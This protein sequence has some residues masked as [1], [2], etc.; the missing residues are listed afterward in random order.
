LFGPAAGIGIFDAFAMVVPGVPLI[1]SEAADEE[2]WR[3][4]APGGAVKVWSGP[5]NGPRP[6]DPIAADGA[7]V[8]L[9]SA[10]TTPTWSIFRYTAAAGVELVAN[11]SDHPVAVAGP[12]A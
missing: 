1:M 7:T 4:P 12:C 8:W 11:F 9:S 5:T 6:Y 3:V 10:N 2:L